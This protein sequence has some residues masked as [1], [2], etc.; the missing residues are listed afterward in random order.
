MSLR[1]VSRAD[2]D[3]NCSCGTNSSCTVPQGFYCRTTNC[4]PLET[5]P[6]QTVPGL[7]VSCLPVDSLL[8]SS[9]ECFYNISCIQMLI[10]WYSYDWSNATVDPR[11]VN[12]TPLNPLISSRFPPTT[13]LD[14]IVSQ[15]FVEDWTDSNNFSSYYSQCAPNECTY[16]YEERFNIAYLVSTIFGIVGGLS[17]ALRILIPPIV[18]LIRRMYQHCCRPQQCFERD[19]VVK[20]GKSKY[21]TFSLCILNNE[22]Y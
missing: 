21:I 17:V 6:N 1:F 4:N 13:T 16:T 15:L 8:L 20:K 19:A 7:V 10:E 11:A 14:N 9:L 5:K 22:F 18:T 12:V 3:N 2:Y